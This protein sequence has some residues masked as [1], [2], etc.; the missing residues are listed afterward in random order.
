MSSRGESLLESH[1]TKMA[2]RF[3]SGLKFRDC[4]G[5]GYIVGRDEKARKQG[6]ADIAAFIA[7]KWQISAI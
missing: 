1:A 5:Y 2:A 4:V 3:S 6:Y 7:E